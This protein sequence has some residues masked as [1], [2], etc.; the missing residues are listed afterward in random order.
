RD[1]H[2]LPDQG[3]HVHVAEIA[4][5]EIEP[6][7]VPQHQTEALIGRLVEAELL[8]EAGDEFRIEPLGAAVFGAGR[9]GRAAAHLPARP[10]V[11]RGTGDARG[12]A[13]VGA[14]ELGDDALDRTAGRE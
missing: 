14:A 2:L 3:E 11:A 10:E 9:I 1:R 12:P 7:V 5:A 8:L 13:G 4:L 6:A